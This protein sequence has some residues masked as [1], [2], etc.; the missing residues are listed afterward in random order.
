ME[1]VNAGGLNG[2]FDIDELGRGH[3]DTHNKT[4]ISVLEMMKVV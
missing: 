2:A 3:A 1:I 4:L